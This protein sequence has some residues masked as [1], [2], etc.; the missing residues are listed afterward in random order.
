MWEEVVCVMDIFWQ[1]FF[2]LLGFA[3]G[4]SMA[5][6]L[7]KQ[8]ADH[9]SDMPVLLFPYPLVEQRRGPVPSVRISPKA[10]WS[11]NE[12]CQFL[13]LDLQ[14]TNQYGAI[15]H[16]SFTLSFPRGHSSS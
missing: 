3:I 8:H 7:R 11:E 4:V 15:S 9:S 16:G 13:T 10:R 5:I 2:P 6:Y 12:K 1:L 14:M